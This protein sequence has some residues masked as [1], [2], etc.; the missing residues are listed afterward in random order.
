MTNRGEV[1]DEEMTEFNY[2]YESTILIYPHEM[3][4]R[5]GLYP[6]SPEYLHR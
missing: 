2:K 3:F 5:Y 6:S 4:V 1:G